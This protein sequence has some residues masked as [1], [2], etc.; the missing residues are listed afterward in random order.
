MK[1]LM[2]GLL[3]YCNDVEEN[4]NY[5][6]SKI[7]ETDRKTSDILH[8]IELEDKLS[9]A[10][11]YETYKL[12]KDIRQER[13]KYK[14][15]MQEFQCLIGDIRNLSDKLRNQLGNDEKDKKRYKVK[16]LQELLGDY[17]D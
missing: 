4:W 13:R 7:S 12:L 16:E 10:K 3:D 2:E 17:I 1:K 14:D 5:L 9:A 6:N 15:K 11:G 8:F